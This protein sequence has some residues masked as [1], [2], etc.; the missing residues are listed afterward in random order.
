M[1]AIVVSV[2]IPVVVSGVGLVALEVV[3]VAVS[4]VLVFPGVFSFADLFEGFVGDVLVL[5]GF[6]VL[7]VDFVVEFLVF[8]DF[9]S[10]GFVCGFILGRFLC[11]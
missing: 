9:F 2:S 11:V 1:S 7:V 5:F 10:L 4:F 3:S 8:G 6:V